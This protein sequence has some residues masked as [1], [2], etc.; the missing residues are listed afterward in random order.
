MNLNT[1]LRTLYAQDNPTYAYEQRIDVRNIDVDFAPFIVYHIETLR[2]QFPKECT[3][4]RR[5]RSSH[6]CKIVTYQLLGMMA[7]KEVGP[8]SEIIVAPDTVCLVYT[9]SRKDF[10][11]WFELV[12]QKKPTLTA[13]L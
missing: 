13:R 7:E 1:A 11:L 6:P 4:A 8:H 2:F 9:R 12:L 3:L 5:F 10:V